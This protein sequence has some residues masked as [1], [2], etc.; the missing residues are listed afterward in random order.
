MVAMNESNLQSLLDSVKVSVFLLQL[1]SQLFKFTLKLLN[2]FTSL[3]QLDSSLLYLNIL[4]LYLSIFLL[5]SIYSSS[6][7]SLKDNKR[8][9]SISILIIES[10]DHQC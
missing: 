9:H 7:L 5:D 10:T 4:V 2:P 1:C 8:L 3:L 6:P